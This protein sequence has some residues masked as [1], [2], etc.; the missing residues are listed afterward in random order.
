[1]NGAIATLRHRAERQLR[2]F[3]GMPM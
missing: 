3:V 1:M 2:Q